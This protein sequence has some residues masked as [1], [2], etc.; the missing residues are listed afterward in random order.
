[1]DLKYAVEKMQ[2]NQFRRS[3]TNLVLAGAAFAASCGYIFDIE[4]LKWILENGL[5]IAIAAGQMYISSTNIRSNR[6]QKKLIE[7]KTDAEKISDI[8]NK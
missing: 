1:M 7:E 5:T 2:D 4:W 8:L 6:K 3:L